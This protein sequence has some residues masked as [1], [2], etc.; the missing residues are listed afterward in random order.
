MNENTPYHVSIS[1]HSEENS[2]LFTEGGDSNFAVSYN[3]VFNNSYM[4]NKKS[5][6]H[7]IDMSL[8]FEELGKLKGFLSQ[9][10]DERKKR[11][12]KASRKVKRHG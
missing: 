2:E 3:S 10:D 6:R 8:N 1:V 9:L 11:A 7:T 4:R 5:I 12:L